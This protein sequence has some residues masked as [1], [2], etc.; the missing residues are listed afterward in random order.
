MEALKGK[1]LPQT[2]LAATGKG[3]HFYFKMPSDRVIGNSVGIFPKVDVR[4]E[5]GYVVAP[6]SIH[7]NGAKYE[8]IFEDDIEDLP[9]WLYEA[10]RQE[11]KKLSSK[12]DTPNWF[13]ELL[14]GVKE[15]GRNAAAARLAGH[16]VKKG[17]E[18]S[19]ILQLMFSW[20]RK[21]VPPMS[22]KDI[23]A[24]VKSIVSRDPGTEE[25]LDA[26]PTALA[27]AKQ[28]LSK[29]LY[30]KDDTM[31][32]VALATVASLY[33]PADPLWV[34][35]VGPPSSG[36]TEI[37]RALD[38]HEDTY[39]IDNLTPSTFVTG[40]T[41]AKGILE[42]MGE[43]QKTFVLQDLSTLIS[44]PPYDRM[45]IVDQLRQI[46]NGSYYNEWGNGKKFSW[47]GKAG[48][49]AGCTPEIEAQHIAMGELG[50]RFLYY[51]TDADDDDTR[52]KMME[53]ARAME[54]L[55][56][57][58]RE[59]IARAVHGVIAAV[60]GKMVSAVTVENHYLDWLASLVDMTTTLR[61]AVKR[62][63]YNRDIIEYTPHKEGPG[64]MYKACQVLIKSLALVRGRDAVNEKDYEVVAKVCVDSMPSV[65]RESMHALIKI[66]M[67]GGGG[68]RAKDVAKMTGYQA[69]QSVQSHLA[70][71]AALGVVSR[72]VKEGDAGFESA[73]NSPWLYE[74]KPAMLERLE[75]CGLV[76]IL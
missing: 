51:R 48:L 15:G 13:E 69:T 5:G 6:G 45:Q 34:V 35:L 64:R 67:D 39:F 58:A 54:G 11:K 27:E 8:W 18:P 65:R 57:Q 32:D 56:K 53:K 47:K 75:K 72:W 20:N 71:L 43:Q 62:N 30:F 55:E 2:R 60:K 31:I 52:V 59:E 29:W 23:E 42:R 74:I 33:H 25:I 28:V 40:F 19:D 7:P 76:D 4:G 16:W 68:V 66:S 10:Q 70:D 17:Y 24:V 36:K 1:E 9:I 37:L 3:K 46:Y 50:E 26:K 41:K 14:A 73:T 38:R 21:N 61:S 22:D 49:V 12:T 44:K 63:A